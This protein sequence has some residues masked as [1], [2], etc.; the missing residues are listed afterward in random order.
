MGFIQFPLQNIFKFELVIHFIQFQNL[1][2]KFYEFN[3]GTEN[4]LDYS[5]GS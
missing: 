1:A 3:F 5:K 4:R 2:Q